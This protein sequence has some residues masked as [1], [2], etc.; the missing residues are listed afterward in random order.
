MCQSLGYHRIRT[1]KNESPAGTQYRQFLFW[2]VY[3]FD[4]S[5]SLRLG[6]SSTI[7]DY[8]VTVP[9]P[10]NDG[11]RQSPILS[12]FGLWVT[13]SRIQGQIYELLYCP[14]AVTQSEAVRKSRAQLLLSQLDKLDSLTQEVSVRTAQN[15]LGDEHTLMDIQVKWDK[16]LR[17][18]NP[19]DI[20]DYFIISD[21]V[22]RLST[23]TLIHRAVPN[24]PGSPTTF[25]VECIQTARETLARHQECMAVVE[26]TTAGLFSS[27]MNWSVHKPLVDIMLR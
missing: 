24:P 17:E 16:F 23:R 27:Y 4:K 3:T 22:L 12:F 14:E 2:V 26:R 20:T 15:C 6:R 25:A 18:T 11:L 1:Y 21:H 7:Q 9:E 8:D 5:L 10:R 19:E 13:E